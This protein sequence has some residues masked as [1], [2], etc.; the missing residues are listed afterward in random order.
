VT[1]TYV[2]LRISKAAYQEIKKKLE[3][4]DYQHTFHEDD[5]EIVIDMHG[6]A[7]AEAKK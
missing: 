4:A 7:V 1:H 2:V 5:G 3:E 6:I